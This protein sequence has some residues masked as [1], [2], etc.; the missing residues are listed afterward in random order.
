MSATETPPP[1]R[2]Y[3]GAQI[4]AI[5]VGGILLLPGLCSLVFLLGMVWELRLNDPIARMIVTLWVICF[6]VSAG[7]LALILGARKRRS[8]EP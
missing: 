3:S 6:L 4:A 8:S 7:G 5:V 2:R 1:P